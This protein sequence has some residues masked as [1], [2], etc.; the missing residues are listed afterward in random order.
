MEQL[1]QDLNLDQIWQETEQYL[2][3]PDKVL[4]ALPEDRLAVAV[5]ELFPN[6]IGEFT[7]TNYCA[8]VMSSLKH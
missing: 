1:R 3:D 5:A 6:A 2:P 4:A 7:N 8:F